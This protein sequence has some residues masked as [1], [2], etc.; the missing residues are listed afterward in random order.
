[1][2]TWEQKNVDLRQ[3]SDRNHINDRR[4]ENTEPEV[5]GSCYKKAPGTSFSAGIAGVFPIIYTIA[6]SKSVRD[7]IHVIPGN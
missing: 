5:F 3:L 4:T 6:V 1:M 7:Y 2:G